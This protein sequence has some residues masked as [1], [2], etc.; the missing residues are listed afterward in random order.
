M[1]K[2]ISFKTSK[3]FKNKIIF[4]FFSKTGGVSKKDFNSLN[5]GIY[6]KDKS[7][8][9]NKN[10]KLALTA[11]KLSNY[12]VI[13]AKQIHSNK[14]KLID[15]NFNY[16]KRYK[17]DGFVTKKNNLALSILTADCA[18]IFFMTLKEI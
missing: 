12:K 1:N 18:P 2:N 6:T 13:I 8:N 5:C 7:K 17:V 11:L 15:R 3:Y 14:I 10:I 16:K 9:I 4:G